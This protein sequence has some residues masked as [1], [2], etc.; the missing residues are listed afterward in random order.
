MSAHNQPRTTLPLAATDSHTHHVLP[1]LDAARQHM[2]SVLTL[3]D[4]CDP[5]AWPTEPTTDP[6][7]AAELRTSVVALIKYARRHRCP[8]C[9]PGRMRATLRLSALLLDL[10]QTAKHHVQHPE[11]YPLTLPK[12]S[13]RVFHD[14]AGW[15]ATG[16]ARRL[17]GQP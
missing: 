5:P 7:R 6:I 15:V 14:L 11:Q 10:W 1:L 12:R 13:A 3:L 16:E 4:L 9:K 17:L 2:A 8:D